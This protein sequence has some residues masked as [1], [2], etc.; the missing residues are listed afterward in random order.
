[1]ALLWIGDLV[2]LVVVAPAVLFFLNKVRRPIQ[3]IKGYAD[4][5]LEHGVALTGTVDAVPKL[6][7]TCELTGAARLAVTRYG[8]ALARMLEWAE[9]TGKNG[10]TT[11]RERATR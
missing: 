3:E 7:E 8:L 9:P 11:R 4:D 10:R 2:L 6:V 5:I 1:M